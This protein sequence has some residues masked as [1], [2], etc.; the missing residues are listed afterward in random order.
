MVT[1]R[2]VVLPALYAHARTPKALHVFSLSLRASQHERVFLEEENE[3]T[4]TG[5]APAGLRFYLD[6]VLKHIWVRAD[7]KKASLDR[8]HGR[9]PVAHVDVGGIQQG[10][11]GVKKV[12]QRLEYLQSRGRKKRSRGGRGGRKVKT[13][14]TFGIAAASVGA[15]VLSCT[16]VAAGEENIPKRQYIL[17]P[18]RPLR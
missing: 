1:C 6:Q 12:V 4:K 13:A 3:P 15:T 8:H 10:F 16:G 14:G 7:D 2:L 17:A 18:R 5:V 11:L 9:S